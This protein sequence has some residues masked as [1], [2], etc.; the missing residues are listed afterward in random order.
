M[1]PITVANCAPAKCALLVPVPQHQTCTRTCIWA[2]NWM[3]DIK[4]LAHPYTTPIGVDGTLESDTYGS[5]LMR[6]TA[7]NIIPSPGTFVSCCRQSFAAQSP[8]PFFSCCWLLEVCLA[9]FV[10]SLQTTVLFS[11]LVLTSVE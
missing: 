9:L 3:P 7:D 10:A 1:L 11:F 2:L 5:Y 8:P 4:Y 6:G